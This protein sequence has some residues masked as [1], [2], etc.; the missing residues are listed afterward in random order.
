VAPLLA[1]V[2]CAG[3]AHAQVNAYVASTGNTSVLVLDT[4]TNTATATITGTGARRRTLSPDG[5][6]VYSTNSNGISKIDTATNTITGTV[7]TGNLV[8]GIVVTPDGATAYVGNNASDTVSVIDTAT[9]TVTTTLP[10]AN[11]AIAITPD[12]A[13]VW[14]S[15]GSLSGARIN[16]IDTATNTVTNFPVGHGLNGPSEID[17]TPDGAFAYLTNDDNT[18]SVIDTA[19]Q[20][21]VAA[22]PV[23]SLPL[24]V[25]LTLDGAFAYAL[26]LL[27]PRGIAFTPDGAFAYVTNF[28]GDSISVIDT[29]TLIGALIDEIEALIA[30]GALAPNKANPLI[31]KL[32]SVAAKLDGGQVGA[33]CNQLG[34]FINQI[35]AYIGNGT[36]TPAQGA[37]AD[38]RGERHQG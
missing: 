16:A 6:F 32:E 31:T 23:G 35:N 13:S 28:N 12:G 5:M 27:F 25:T 36:L 1:L 2:L 14:V 30:G 15:T 22:V 8:I 38:R 20:T 17:F 10:L 21:E 3:S 26:N 4:A 19:T 7:A 37:G 29:A 24:N 33:A 9:L 11:G 34:A 18:V